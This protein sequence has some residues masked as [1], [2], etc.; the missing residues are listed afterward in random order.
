MKVAIFGLHIDQILDCN[1]IPG[2]QISV[3]YPDFIFPYDSAWNPH[4]IHP[5][6]PQIRQANALLVSA[7]AMASCQQLND[8]LRVLAAGLERLWC[9]GTSW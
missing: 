7:S 8:A 3:Q 9:H 4:E 5:K 2:I 6:I 1:S